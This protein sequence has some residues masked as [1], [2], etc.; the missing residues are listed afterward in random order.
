[1]HK[2][3][4]VLINQGKGDSSG[5]CRHHVV[6]HLDFFSLIF[7]VFFFQTLLAIV[8]SL[9][10]PK[11]LHDQKQKLHLHNIQKRPEVPINQGERDQV[12][13]MSISCFCSPA[14]IVNLAPRY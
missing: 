2:R 5:S 11:L 6:V 9:V 7:K 8:V 13:I 10:R 12:Q 4:E 14:N 1:M 3:P